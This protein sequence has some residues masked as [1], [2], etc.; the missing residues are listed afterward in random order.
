LLTTLIL[1]AITIRVD[2][3]PVKKCKLQQLVRPFSLGKS[4]L[5][6]VAKHLSLYL[7]DEVPE[8]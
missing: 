7:L 6:I 4:K 3:I 8:I 2:F 5:T 1:W